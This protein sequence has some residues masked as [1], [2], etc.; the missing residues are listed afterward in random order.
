V[1]H[2]YRYRYADTN[3]NI[4]IERSASSEPLEQYRET[5]REYLLERGYKLV[6]VKEVSA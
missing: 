6:S 1:T 2:F 4:G 3:G 5:L